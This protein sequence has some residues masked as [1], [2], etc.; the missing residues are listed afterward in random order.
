MRQV[1]MYGPETCGP[2]KTALGQPLGQHRPRSSST[3]HP[4]AQPAPSKMPGSTSTPGSSSRSRDYAAAADSPGA[5]PPTPST[6]CSTS[7]AAPR[8]H[9]A[10]QQRPQT[11]PRP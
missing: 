4:T 10:D 1:V 7:T 6:A 3:S 2:P 5:F 11:S 8:P 9:G